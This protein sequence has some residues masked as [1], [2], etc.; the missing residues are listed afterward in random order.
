MVV[1]VKE[2]TKDSITN[3]LSKM[4]KRKKKTLTNHF[5]KLKRGIDGLEYQKNVRN[6]WN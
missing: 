3:L 6:E 1:E 2:I 5:G 4:K